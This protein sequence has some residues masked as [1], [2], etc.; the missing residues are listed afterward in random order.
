M[1]SQSVSVSM[2][3]HQHMVK[4]NFI[5]HVGAG[6][7]N[8]WAN[9]CCLVHLAGAVEEGGSPVLSPS[10]LTYVDIDQLPISGG[11]SHRLRR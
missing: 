8:A 3:T 9:N 4:Y 11:P 6:V 1:Q 10:T 5:C 7:E 2:V